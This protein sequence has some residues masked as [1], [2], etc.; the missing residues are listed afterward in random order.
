MV[1]Q[2]RLRK[3]GARP[4]KGRYIFWRRALSLC[5]AI[6]ISPFRKDWYIVCIIK[7]VQLVNIGLKLTDLDIHQPM[8][9]TRFQHRRLFVMTCALGNASFEINFEYVDGIQTISG[10]ITEFTPVYMPRRGKDACGL[11]QVTGGLV[12]PWL[13]ADVAIF[14]SLTSAPTGN[15]TLGLDY[16]VTLDWS[17]GFLDI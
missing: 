13:T 6:Y 8:L 10:K 16:D 3:R 7:E 15:I 17:T 9:Q 11:W 1:S 5:L 2:K 14:T 12:T 4:V